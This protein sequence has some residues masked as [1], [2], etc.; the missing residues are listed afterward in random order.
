MSNKVDKTD[1][2]IV[3]Y[4]Q[5]DADLFLIYSNDWFI[6]TNF[7]ISIENIEF[8]PLLGNI[9]FPISQLTRSHVWKQHLPYNDKSQLTSC[10]T[11]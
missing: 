8:L 11:G 4:K 5:I 6:Q 2:T 9:Y 3:E 1:G 7:K 10:T